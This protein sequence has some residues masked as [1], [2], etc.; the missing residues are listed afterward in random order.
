MLVVGPNRLFLRYIAQVLPSLGE[1]SVVQT[2]LTGLSALDGRG[3]DDDAVA[4][5]KG[6]LR[7]AEVIERAAWGRTV[8]LTEDVR[9]RT[10][11]GNLTLAAAD[12]NDALGAALADRRTVA[13]TPRGVPGVGVEAGLRAPRGPA[14]GGHEALRRSGDRHSH[15]PRSPPAAGPGVAGH[16]RRRRSCGAC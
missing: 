1:T 6:D 13:S 10:S 3:T 4:A 8:A 16:H 14:P 2:T 12:V 7:L 11:Y 9:V 5:L 15:E